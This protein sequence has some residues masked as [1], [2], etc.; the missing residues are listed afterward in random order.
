MKEGEGEEIQKAGALIGR[1]CK[2]H[3]SVPLEL[4]DLTVLVVAYQACPLP[5][6][7]L[8]IP[9]AALNGLITSS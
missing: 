7:A 1:L 8:A 3:S 5:F 9:A 2:L 4:S 6:A